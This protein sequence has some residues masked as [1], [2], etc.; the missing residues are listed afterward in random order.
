MPDRR[1]SPAVQLAAALAPESAEV[2]NALGE[3]FSADHAYAEAEHHFRRGLA[4]A[5]RDARMHCRLARTLAALGRDNESHESYRLALDIDP[6]DAEILVEAAASALRQ[7][8][9]ADAVRLFTDAARLRPSDGTIRH[10]LGL[11]LAHLG[12]IRPALECYAQ[13]LQA[14]P[15]DAAV[16]VD[17]AAA[18]MACG[19][20]ES[21]WH[22]Y[23]WRWRLPRGMRHNP[24]L[25]Q[26]QWDGSPLAGSSVLVCGEQDPSM[27]L[28]FATCYPAIVESADRAILLSDPKL[29]T[30]LQALVPRATVIPCP[31]GLEHRALS[32]RSVDCQVSAGSLPRYLGT[33]STG[34]SRRGA[35]C[36]RL[37][38]MSLPFGK[39]CTR[40]RLACASAL[41]GT[42]RMRRPTAMRSW[43]LG[44]L[45]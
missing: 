33:R 26:P 20:L 7:G 40:C 21:A 17:R 2:W 39:D 24:L 25:R 28:L 36:V 1:G 45:Y 38:N 9:P 8:N 29:A 44:N 43:Q 3:N 15:D 4:C 12:Q 18:L 22:D 30:L 14:N 31:R 16:R 6:R 37:Q 19:D 41:L 10:H 27:E 42:R 23:E 34:P 11:V 5:L 32:G 13:A 35:Y